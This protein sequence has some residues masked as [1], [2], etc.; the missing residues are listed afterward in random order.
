[1]CSEPV[2][3]T[4]LSG[5]LRAELLADGHEAG[6]LV[7]GDGDFLATPVSQGDVLD[8]IIGGAGERWW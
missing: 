4:P 6:H 2:T 3:R 8:V 1:M 5:L 7:L